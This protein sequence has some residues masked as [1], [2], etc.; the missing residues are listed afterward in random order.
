MSTELNHTR[1]EVNTTAVNQNTAEYSSVDHGEWR[2][3]HPEELW[4]ATKTI[5]MVIESPADVAVIV[6]NLTPR[7]IKLA[8]IVAYEMYHHIQKII[9]AEMATYNLIKL[10]TVY[11][12]SQ[13]VLER[14]GAGLPDMYSNIV[15][16]GEALNFKVARETY[17]VDVPAALKVMPKIIDAIF[18]NV[19]FKKHIEIKIQRTMDSLKEDIKSA[20]QQD[21]NN[22]IDFALVYA[23]DQSAKEL[24]R[25]FFDMSSLSAAEADLIY[26]LDFSMKQID[27]LL[28]PID[29]NLLGRLDLIIKEAHANV[30]E[31]LKSISLD[32]FAYH[33]L[34][35]GPFEKGGIGESEAITF[36][37][38]NSRII[39]GITSFEESEKVVTLYERLITSPAFLREIKVR[40]AYQLIELNSQLPSNDPNYHEMYEFEIKAALANLTVPAQLSTTPIIMSAQNEQAIASHKLLTGQQAF[41]LLDHPGLLLAGASGAALLVFCL[42]KYSSLSRMS[43]SLSGAIKAGFTLMSQK[44][45]PEIPYY[46]ID[47]QTDSE[48]EDFD[49]IPFNP[50]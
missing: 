23:K 34:A 38:K 49:R 21:R 13:I 1:S 2:A 39:Q 14:F 9:V 30:N 16:R 17:N 12:I 50:R 20:Q 27:A 46:K 10:P 41:N 26:L 32:N 18:V 36:C 43:S 29:K 25:K 3:N 45:Y 7:E 35:F 11:Q 5:G 6:N 33:E 44:R 8:P 28:K 15:P 48:D 19:N 37:L 24:E 4:D 22:K 47:L 42:I 31:W 40:T